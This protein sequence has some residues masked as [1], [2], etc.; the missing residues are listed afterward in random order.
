MNDLITLREKLLMKSFIQILSLINSI[1]SRN[2]V[3]DLNQHL[4]CI[5][6]VFNIHYLFFESIIIIIITSGNITPISVFLLY[7]CVKN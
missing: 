6:C 1:I 3:Y 4:L 5:S 2:N 7:Y